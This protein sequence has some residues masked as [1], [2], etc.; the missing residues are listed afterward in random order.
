MV[1]TIVALTIPANAL[2][3]CTGQEADADLRRELQDLRELRARIQSQM[4][5]LIAAM[6]GA[7]PVPTG[8]PAR[9]R[10]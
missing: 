4:N 6:P 3:Q 2:A 5:E 10:F 8:A 1:V 7:A 9:R